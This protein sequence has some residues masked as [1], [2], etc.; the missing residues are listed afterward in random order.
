MFDLCE[1]IKNASLT[2]YNTYHI[3]TE[4]SYLAFPKN[5]NELTKLLDYLRSNKIS[6]FIMGNGSNIILSD[7]KYN[8]VVVN[9]T[10][11]KKLA[12]DEN[13]NIIK[14]TAGVMLPQIVKEAVNHNLQGLE[15]ASGIPGTI[16]GSIYGNAGAYL[17]CIIDYL[18]EVTVYYKNEIKT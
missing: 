2:N 16:G 11:M 12:I 9:L 4:C 13:K 7:N 15:W 10:K 17:S 18:E 6:Y 8:G 3:K 1:I 14:A 5:V